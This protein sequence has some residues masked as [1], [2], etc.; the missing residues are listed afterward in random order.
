[1]VLSGDRLD[2]AWDVWSLP[3]PSPRRSQ[4]AI[5]RLLSHL[6]PDVGHGSDQDPVP[7]GDGAESR[8]LS[9][10][11]LVAFRTDRW[12]GPTCTM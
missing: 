6:W 5:P 10:N 9:P 12:P 1:M 8:G 3:A 11:S 2:G 4:A 7:T